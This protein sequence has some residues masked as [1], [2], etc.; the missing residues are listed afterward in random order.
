VDDDVADDAARDVDAATRSTVDALV[1][2]VVVEWR[3]WLRFVFTILRASMSSAPSATAPL[4]DAVVAFARVTPRRVD[5]LG[6]IVR[7]LGGRVHVVVGDDASEAAATTLTAPTL[8]VLGDGTSDAARAARQTYGSSPLMVRAEY[9]AACARAEG[10]GGGGVALEDFVVVESEETETR[11]E[12][13]VIDDDDDGGGGEAWTTVESKSSSKSRRESKKMASQAMPLGWPTAPKA[14][15]VLV[16]CGPSGSGKS[17][18]SNKLP[19]DKWVV[20]N[21]DTIS[22]GRPG[23]RQQCLSL[24]KRSL[25]EGKHVV[26]DRCG[27]SV[28]Q[29]EDF[30]ALAKESSPQC[31]LH[32]VWFNQPTSV[33]AKRAQMRRNHP[34]GVEGDFAVRV[35][36][37]QSRRKDNAPPTKD[38]GF[39]T[40]RRCRYQDDVDTALGTYRAIPSPTI[41]VQFPKKKA[42]ARAKSVDDAMDV[43]DADESGV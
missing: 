36:Q 17:T 8:V 23:S 27:L 35:V 14:P 25:R 1:G 13:V 19:A 15:V 24:A 12:V 7:R 33:Y 31:E 43:D 6:A 39:K 28:Q 20:A 9:L 18:F 41:S 4:A 38:E 29:R 37:M 5:A 32:C 26:I 42:S 40:I 34:S 16:L 22:N 2:I 3:F 30:V 10:G 11:T 21:Q